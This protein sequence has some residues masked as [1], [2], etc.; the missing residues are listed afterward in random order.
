[1]LPRLAVSSAPTD[2]TRNSRRP[3]PPV[4][5]DQRSQRLQRLGKTAVAAV[6][7]ALT[8]FSTAC[9][10]PGATI[11]NW[12]GR[13]IDSSSVSVGQGIALV[14]AVPIGSN[15]QVSDPAGRSQ[16]VV[17]KSITTQHPDIRGLIVSSSEAASFAS[18]QNFAADWQLPPSG[19]V[20]DN[21][22]SLA[23]AVE[24]AENSVTTVLIENGKVIGSW[25]NRVV[26]VQEIDSALSET[27]V[28]TSSTPTTAP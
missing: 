8:T 9:S 25:S 10:G 2:C 18:L 19:V 5:R 23:Q 15:G 24:S 20:G 14:S 11:E 6:M 26:L 12:K 16:I 22:A 27:S 1:M 7:L 17:L 4:Q 13:T 3:L 21:A 28:S